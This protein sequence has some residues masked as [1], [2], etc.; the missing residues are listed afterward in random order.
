MSDYNDSIELRELTEDQK[1]N[2][3]DRIGVRLFD[4]ERSDTMEGEEI[5]QNLLIE[6]VGQELDISG[7]FSHVRFGDENFTTLLVSYEGH[8]EDE[9]K[10]FALMILNRAVVC[11]KPQHFLLVAEN[12]K[13]KT[14]FIKSCRDLGRIA[15]LK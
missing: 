6:K 4:W 3:T 12:T 8:S 10:D 11:D 2:K 7:T 15:L 9:M 13:N 14:T 5:M 1:N